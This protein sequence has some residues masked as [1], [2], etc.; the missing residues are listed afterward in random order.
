[1]KRPVFF[2]CLATLMCSSSA[3]AADDAQIIK[4]LSQKLDSLYRAKSS[5][6]VMSMTVIT[7]NYKRQLTMSIKTLGMDYTLIRI[8]TPRR[9]KG[10]A[11]LKRRNEMWNYMPKIKRTI[12]LPASMMMGSWMG[13][14]LTNDDLVRNSSWE[15]DYT[16][17]VTS[18]NTS[19]ICITFVPKPKAAV[20][21]SKIESCFD[22]K[23]SLP[24]SQSFFDEKGK[25]VR[26]MT[27]DQVKTLGG[28]T[29]PTRMTLIPL[30][31]KK[32]GH[33]TVM[34]FN[35]MKYDVNLKASD[36]T[37]TKLRR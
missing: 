9:E 11:T 36:F 7:P 31:D 33:K 22:A 8:K 17:K 12:R 15:K 37:L 23:T 18:R 29:I 20:T 16:A 24:K 32:K 5:E 30:T 3:F 1:M 21:W 13:S 25:K 26:L 35:Q 28:R 6:G 19:Q 4:A 10:I 14:D 27:F 34:Q 2:L